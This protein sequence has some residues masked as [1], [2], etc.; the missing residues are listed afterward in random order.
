MLIKRRHKGRNCWVWDVRLINEHGEK[1]LYPTGHTSK[2]L[3]KEYEQ[4]KRNEIAELKMFPERA[5]KKILFK[6]FAPIYLDKH[7]AK[8]RSYRDYVSDCKK[9]V[10][11]FDKYHLHEIERFIIETYY[12]D[13]LKEVSEYMANQEIR[14]LK[15]MFTKA[16]EWGFAAKNP[17]KGF[18]LKNE[19]PRQ[20]FLRGWEIIKLM[21]TAGQEPKAPHLRPMV[22]MDIGTGLRKEELLSVEIDHVY[23]DRNTLK[24]EGKGGYTRY[25]PFGETVK[26]EIIKL[27]ERPNGK[28]LFH[29][30]YGPRIRDIKKSFRS[31]ILRAG[32]EDVRFHDLRRTF[33]TMCALNRVPPKTLQ[34]WMGHK[35]I[36]TTMKY[37]VVS[38][39]EFEQEEMKRLDVIMDTYVDTSKTAV[40]AESAEL[41]E[42]SGEPCRIRTCDPLIKSQLLY[43]LS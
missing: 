35:D 40:S 20:R 31:A 19:K 16:V 26:R 7:A 3:A 25:V 15:G 14:I 2:K 36:Q 4:K 41:I 42:K 28:Y 27:L 23:L 5:F 10:A 39:E 8:Q 1:E 13:R 9:L 38:P 11:F 18:K 29:D 33:G 43:Q 22:I 34:G 32:L 12:S 24:I 37:Y 17:V 21:E 6:D 30:R